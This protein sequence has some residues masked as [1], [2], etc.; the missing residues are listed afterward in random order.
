MTPKPRKEP[1]ALINQAPKVPAPQ[2]YVERLCPPFLLQ[3]VH[4]SRNL[5]PRWFNRSEAD[6]NEVMF[7]EYAAEAE[8]RGE[9]PTHQGYMTTYGCSALTNQLRLRFWTEVDKARV[10]GQA[11]MHLEDL[12]SGICTE[13][14]YKNAL[15]RL[16]VVAWIF[17][18]PVGYI[19]RLTDM[20]DIGL[21]N[22]REIL[23]VPNVGLSGQL[24][25]VKTASLKLKIVEMA[26]LRLRGS[27]AQNLNIK[28][29]NY[30]EHNV[31]VSK[32]LNVINSPNPSLE[33]PKDLIVDRLREI[34]E[35][36]KQLEE[37]EMKNET[38]IDVEV[39]TG[40]PDAQNKTLLNQL[41]KREEF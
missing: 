3:R 32:E 38:E 35:Q 21:R 39:V 41:N 12:Y 23:A 33:P 8:V 17:T 22:M 15:L 11:K 40:L 31:H 29:E 16:D 2:S 30:M 4:E 6:L 14:T 7:S 27:V 13:E 5:Y 1:K 24:M 10:M 18:Q 34:E 25:C 28:S 9:K 37:I 20:L 36:I 26:L 19:D